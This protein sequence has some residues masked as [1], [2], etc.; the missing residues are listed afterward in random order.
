MIQS[1]KS[2]TNFMLYTNKL[3]FSKK[4]INPKDNILIIGS[5]RSGTTW[6]M[7]ILQLL[8]NYTYLSEPINPILFPEAFTIGFTS[9]TY[10]PIDNDWPSGERHLDKIFRG[11]VMNHPIPARLKDAENNQ[12]NYSPPSFQKQLQDLYKLQPKTLINHLF[13]KKLVVKFVRLNRLL[14][15]ISQRFQLR[16]I[17]FIIRHPCAVIASQLNTGF[18]GYHPSSPPYTDIYPSLEMLLHEASKIEGLSPN[19]LQKL[20]EIKTREEILAATWCLDNLIPLS[21]AKPY[22]WTV[23][24]YE[25]LIKE[26]E[27]ELKR[28]FH[29]IGQKTIP[30]DC[31]KYLKKPSKLTTE[32]EQHIVTQRDK[33]LSKWKK[34]LSEEQI[35]RILSVVSDFGLDFYNE[36]IEPNYNKINVT[37]MSL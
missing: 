8:P 34:K 19:V 14:P 3:I 21:H 17:I 11:H 2:F 12:P 24:T 7:E 10:L 9:R 1:E 25:K 29:E 26:G 22:P 6:L 36:N 30:P 23:V 28:I 15:W 13:A 4:K 33:Q 27:Q 37:N 18:C 5:P 16:G 20:K 35:K 32:Q 31:Y